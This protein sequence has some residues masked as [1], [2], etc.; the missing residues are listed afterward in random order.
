MTD[1]ERL[2]KACAEALQDQVSESTW[3]T[4]FQGIRPVSA[5][6]DRLRTWTGSQTAI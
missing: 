4:F 2:W 5:T 6:S 3:K 1:A